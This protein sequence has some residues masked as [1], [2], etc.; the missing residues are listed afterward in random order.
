M[1]SI[2]LG[3][4]GTVFRGRSGNTGEIV[5]VKEILLTGGGGAIPS[6]V[7]HEVS[8]LQALKHRNIVHLRDVF[9]TET[10]VTLVFEYCYQDLRSYM[11]QYG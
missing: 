9:R 4:F 1:E 7:M 10:K 11:D 2:G 3:G 8:S 6:A 5:A